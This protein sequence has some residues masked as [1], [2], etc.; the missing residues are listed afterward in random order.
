[1][2]EAPGTKLFLVKT[3][4]GHNLKNDP[5][6]GRCRQLCER[7]NLD[8]DVTRVSTAVTQRSGSHAATLPASLTEQALQT[9]AYEEAHKDNR[10]NQL[11]GAP[12]FT[13]IAPTELSH[14]FG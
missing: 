11:L 5:P 6:G 12:A 10:T 7:R 4:P 1:M 13:A 9:I 2:L 14:G 8:I 3:Q